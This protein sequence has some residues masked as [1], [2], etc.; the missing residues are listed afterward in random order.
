M[1]T[2]TRI[3]LMCPCRNAGCVDYG[4]ICN[5]LGHIIDVDTT[6]RGVWDY[7]TWWFMNGPPELVLNSYIVPQCKDLAWENIKTT[8]TEIC[9]K[10]KRECQ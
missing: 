1:C 3:L 8:A 7:C 2:R 5:G 10:C 6:S 9:D 4:D